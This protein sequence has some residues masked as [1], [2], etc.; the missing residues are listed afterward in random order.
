LRHLI[1]D[2]LFRVNFKTKH[3]KAYL[4]LL[5]EHFSIPKANDI[6]SLQHKYKQK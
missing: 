6:S 4:Y 2:M 3:G 1:T 5:C